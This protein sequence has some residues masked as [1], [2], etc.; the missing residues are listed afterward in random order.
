M[1]ICNGNRSFFP[2]GPFSE[3]RDHI[4]FHLCFNKGH[5]ELVL[6]ELV[7]A[8]GR[9]GLGERKPAD[10]K[11]TPR[12]A[13]CLSASD[14]AARKTRSSRADDDPL[15]QQKVAPLYRTTRLAQRTCF[16]RQHY[17]LLLI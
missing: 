14:R 12:G 6:E 9:Q 8:F 11:Q 13:G 16:V 1:L 2:D 3:Y 7:V 5:Y 4:D 17:Q 10:E 15:E